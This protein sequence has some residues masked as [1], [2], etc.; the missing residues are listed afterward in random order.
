M[1]DFDVITGPGPSEKPR[2]PAPKPTPPAKQVSEALPR[3]TLL[4]RIPPRESVAPGGLLP[5][6][7]LNRLSEL[8]EK[9]DFD[10]VD[11][12]RGSRR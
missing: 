12:T 4:P 6:T 9:E 3:A 1:I 11:R 10:Y 8:Q 7:D 2:E 5:G